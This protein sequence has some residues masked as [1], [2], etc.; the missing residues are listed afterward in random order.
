MVVAAVNDEAVLARNLL[1]SPLLA[2]A[3]IPLHIERGAPS[4]SVAYNRGIDAAKAAGAEIVIFAHQDVWFPPLWEAGLRETLAQLD[5]RDP[6]WALL[7]VFGT[8]PEGHRVGRVWSS[9]LGKCVGQPTDGPVQVQGLDELVLILRLASGLRFDEKLP[10][11]HLYGTDIVQSAL[12]GG[13]TAWAATLPVI[14]NSRFVASLG[15]GFAEC[16]AY[17]T[18]KWRDRLPLRTP[19]AR[20]TGRS[21][22]L[23]R[24]RFLFWRTK[25]KRRRAATDHATDPRTLAERCGFLSSEAFGG[26][27]HG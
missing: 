11:F 25:A 21:W 8:A 2:E 9:G 6:G 3:G 17:M 5:S 1:A 4:A 14:H 10:G 19:V 27:V 16:C 15:G 22:P 23:W 24:L 26:A 13:R 12:T 7:G 18:E 20:L